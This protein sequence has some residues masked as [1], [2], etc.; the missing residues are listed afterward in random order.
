MLTLMQ[1]DALTSSHDGSVYS[2]LYKEVWGSRPYNAEFASLEA[3]DE[4]MTYL[5]DKLDMMLAAEDLREKQNF[6]TF[7]ARVEDTMKIVTN[8]DRKQAIAIIA[9]A[10]SLTEKVAWYGYESLEYLFDLKYGSIRKW[11]EAV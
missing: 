4:E 1:I 3:F 5:S 10:E 11:L 2:D 9:D 8:I 6:V 7:V